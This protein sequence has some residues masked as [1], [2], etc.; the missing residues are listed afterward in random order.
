MKRSSAKERIE[1]IKNANKVKLGSVIKWAIIVAVFIILRNPAMLPFLSDSAKESINSVWGDV[2]G[3]MEKISGEFKFNWATCL[4]LVTIVVIMIFIQTVAKYLIDKTKP[5]TPRGRSGIT[6]LRSAVSYITVFVGFFWCLSALGVNVGTIFASVGIVAL[7]IGFGAQSLVEDLVTGIFLLFEDHF[8]V[9][10]I[11][12]I[13]SFR[14]SVESIGIRTTTIRDV[15]GNLKIINNSDLRN[16]LNRSAEDSMAVT[17][18]SVSYDTDI[19]KLEKVIEDLLPEMKKNYP[20]LFLKTP[21]YLGIQELGESGLLLKF[22]AK[23]NEKNVFGAP[24][25]MNRE[26]KIAFDKNGIEIPYNQIVVHD[27]K[28]T[29]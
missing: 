21:E 11:V 23:V 12:E 26:I 22:V 4:K 18:V 20:S 9:G 19:E 7:I 27:A 17:E 8:N 25:V 13:N 15:G 1:R 6:L 16:I 29:K 2:F 5:K 3:D 14:G 24:R 10:D 28:E